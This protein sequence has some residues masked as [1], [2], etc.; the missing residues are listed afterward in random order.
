M[1]IP[2]YWA[3]YSDKWRLHWALG[4]RYVQ[5]T[6]KR[7]TTTHFL[8]A[9]GTILSVAV[10]AY[11]LVFLWPQ[12]ITFS[13]SQPNCLTNPTFFPGLIKTQQSP[14]YDATLTDTI[15]IGAFTLY[16]NKTCVTPHH[17]PQKGKTESI[18]LAA[19][20]NTIVKKTIK[21]TAAAPPEVK[22]HTALKK[23]IAT[24]HR[25]NFNLSEDDHTYT[26]R[27][28]A[29]NQTADCPKKDN[30]ISCKTEALQLAQSTTYEFQLQRMFK[31]TPTE[32][33]F[34]QKLPTV[35]A[36]KV[37]DSSIEP[38]EKIFGKP[39]EITLTLNKTARS[40]GDIKLKRIIGDTKEDVPVTTRAEA[41]KLVVSFT[42]ELPRS[43]QLELH[44]GSID[45]ADKA[46]LATPYVVSF[47][48]SGGPK[49]V[50]INIGGSA[51]PVGHSL[52]LTFDSNP[53]A[54]QNLAQF[55]KVEVGGT[56]VAAN[57]NLRGRTLT[58][59]PRAPLPR[60]SAFSVRV[61]D[62]LHNEAGVS[63]G[64]DWRFNSRTLCQEV[65]SIGRSVQ[66]RGI[67]G[68]RFG[69]GPSKIIFIGAMHGNEKSATAT[70]TSFIN[71]LEANHHRIPAHRTI[72]VI[73]N[74][75]PDGYAANSRTNANNVDLNRNFPAHNWKSGVTMP[76]GAYLE[77]GG[78]SEPMSEPESKAIANFVTSQSP[79]LVIS[80]HSV[81][82]MAIANEKGD[83]LELAGAYGRKMGYWVMGNE[84]S[85]A[86]DYDTTGS[87]EDW[88]AERYG[89]PAIL[90]ELTTRASN[91]FSARQKEAMWA[92]VNAP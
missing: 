79:R 5:K 59:T 34:T 17:P 6:L 66:G 9:V 40:F 58:I 48:T 55:A 28:A 83:S 85:H 78:G 54:G 45:A 27:L 52:T 14:A 32:T 80:Y 25:L 68:Y 90:I 61:L 8:L 73:P 12:S 89:F 53:A 7:V 41:D 2:N 84:S 37:K 24:K 16:S 15:S 29:N 13:Y 23:P 62:G 39:T 4:V 10:L 46:Y 74:L 26:Y 88:M 69:N 50:G 57:Y 19:F 44:I 56:A 38:G 22:M 31:N 76:G 18:T 65:F 60:C 71:D 81:G 42:K 11:G 3:K 64:S 43:A 30:W 75:N 92:I 87:F 86:F 67:T 35:E 77:N 33:I 72:I 91:E 63:G 49:V 1:D 20:G 21:V 51:V 82:G 36:I 70:L 47:T